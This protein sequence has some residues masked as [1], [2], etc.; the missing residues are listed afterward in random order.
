MVHYKPY[1][2]I[3]THISRIQ[4]NIKSLKFY[5]KHF[6]RSEIMVFFWINVITDISDGD[7]SKRIPQMA[8]VRLDTKLCS[9]C[10]GVVS[11]LLLRP[12]SLIDFGAIQVLYLLTYLLTVVLLR[13]AMLKCGLCPVSVGPSVRPSVRHVSGLYPDGW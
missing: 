2:K 3:K 5:G 8:S 1:E 12:D 4:K 9:R 7:I 10:F 6:G 13:D 11:C